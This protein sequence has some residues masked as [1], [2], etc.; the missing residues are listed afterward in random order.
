M[1]DTTYKYLGKYEFSSKIPTIT[2]GNIDVPRPVF[3][4]RQINET[5]EPFASLE[6]LDGVK[7]YPLYIATGGG[8]GSNSDLIQ[9]HIANSSIPEITN[10]PSI[11]GA[12]FLNAPGIATERELVRADIRR[13]LE[14]KEG[15]ELV[16]EAAVNR[17]LSSFYSDELNT[18]LAKG[19]VLACIDH[20]ISVIHES[21]SIYPD[22]VERAKYAK[23]KGFET[24]L[25]SGERDV[26]A[27]VNE[28]KDKIEPSNI[29]KSHQLFS[30]RFEAELLPN[31]DKIQIIDTNNPDK[32]TLIAAKTDFEFTVHDEEAY[33]RF[34]GKG[35]I[36]PQAYASPH[37]QAN[38]IAQQH[39]QGTYPTITP[40][41]Q[42]I[43]KGLGGMAV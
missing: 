3:W 33:A 17:I 25:I 1:S 27:C 30:A 10:I 18:K 8:Y 9:R 4:N 41:S 12:D 38:A 16:T 5:I 40:G 39:A 21:A 26:D 34:L 19:A 11:K 13:F 31:F 15:A 20:G 42:P 24:V 36:D 28:L 35:T 32:H 29:A 7:H 37:A 6:T 23:S 22:T 2:I 43:E 14:A